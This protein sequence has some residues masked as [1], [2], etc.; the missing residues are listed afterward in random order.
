MSRTSGCRARLTNSQT[1]R[2]LDEWFAKFPPHFHQ[3]TGSAVNGKLS[4]LYVRK[5]LARK[6]VISLSRRMPQE[7]FRDLAWGELRSANPDVKEHTAVF[8]DAMTCGAIE[9][10][11]GMHP[12]LIA[13]W[14][15]LMGAVPPHHFGETP[16]ARI[17]DVVAD[18]RAKNGGQAPSLTEIAR[19]LDALDELD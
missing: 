1:T 7:L 11:F 2:R 6:F 18:L 16:G 14:C 8:P 9:D 4:R 17:L 10:D 19:E 13:C 15:C 12:L 3:G 5:R